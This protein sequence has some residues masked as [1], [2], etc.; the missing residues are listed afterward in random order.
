MP[1][2]L[3]YSTQIR[4][5]AEMAGVISSALPPTPLAPISTTPAA[6]G[7]W[8]DEVHWKG[9]SLRQWRAASGD[10]ACLQAAWALMPQLGF[11]GADALL[12]AG[13]LATQAARV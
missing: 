5:A 2:L 3:T 7:G 6:D 1:D 13:A 8:I 9:T 12:L 4:Q 11:D 10:P